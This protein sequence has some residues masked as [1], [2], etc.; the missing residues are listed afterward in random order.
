MPA[1]VQVLIGLI[2][3]DMKKGSRKKVL[4]AV[5]A[6]IGTILVSFASIFTA[7]A[8]AAV[9]NSSAQNGSNSGAVPAIHQRI[10]PQLTVLQIAKLVN[11]I[12]NEHFEDD[13]E[14]KRKE[15][16]NTSNSFGTQ[17][18]AAKGVSNTSASLEIQKQKML[19]MRSFLCDFCGLLNSGMGNLRN[20]LY[21][22][23]AMG[24]PS[25][26]AKC[27]EKTYLMHEK[28]EIERLIQTIQT[29]HIGYIDNVSAYIQAAINIK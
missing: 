4:P 26:I 7:A 6:A 5:A 27:Y 12:A 10:D 29:E 8:N 15:T 13:S 19:E 18:Y 23:V 24:F 17:G 14:R 25:D 28:E 3:I 20:K 22:N 2:M 1:D 9:V 11:E 16:V 21:Q